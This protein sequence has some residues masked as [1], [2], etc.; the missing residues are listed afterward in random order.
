M[1]RLLSSLCYEDG[2][3]DESLW[4]IKQDI[5]VPESYPFQPVKMKFIT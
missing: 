2:Q 1:V 4:L 3:S 5:V